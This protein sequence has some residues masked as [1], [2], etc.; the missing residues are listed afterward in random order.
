MK[1]DSTPIPRQLHQIN[2]KKTPGCPDQGRSIT[3]FTSTTF[4]HHRLWSFHS[5]RRRSFHSIKWF[6][7]R[8]CG[9]WLFQYT[10]SGRWRPRVWLR[11]CKSWDLMKSSNSDSHALPAHP[12]MCSRLCLETVS[13]TITFHLVSVSY[14]L[15]EHVIRI[16]SGILG[17]HHST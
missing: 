12:L 6:S 11:S 10:G 16:C 7:P 13:S 9:R 4:L 15:L 1:N 17:K 3:I 2:K 5:L 8:H 14:Q